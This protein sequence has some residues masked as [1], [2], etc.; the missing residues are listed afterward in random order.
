MLA[1]DLDFSP[2]AGLGFVAGLLADSD[3]MTVQTRAWIMAGGFVT[4]VITV[5]AIHGGYALFRR[6]KG[7]WGSGAATEDALPYDTLFGG[8]SVLHDEPAFS[9]PALDRYGKLLHPA[10]P[11][12]GSE[13][14]LRGPRGRKTHQ[15]RPT[16]KS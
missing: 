9:Q 16:T 2:F 3:P 5:L 6:S 1:N 12:S 14:T 11:K 15:P 8:E 13:K 10:S 4:V 7:N